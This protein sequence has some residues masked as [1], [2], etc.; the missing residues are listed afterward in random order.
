MPPKPL[1]YHPKQGEVL[2]CD[3]SGLVPPEMDKVRWVV[4]ISPKFLNRP[5]LCTVVPISTTPPAKPQAYHVALDN[6]PAP[7]ASGDQAWAKCDMIMTVS[8]ARLT[9]YWNGKDQ[10]GRRKYISLFVSGKELGEI[11]QAVLAALG[12]SNLWKT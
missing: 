8:F 2:R 10:Q 5:D 7:D 11:R 4:V 9:G 6:D 1:P 12:M 3:Y